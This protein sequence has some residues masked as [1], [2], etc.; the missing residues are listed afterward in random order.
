MVDAEAN[1]IAWDDVHK[2]LYVS[3]ASSSANHPDSIGVLDPATGQFT[4][5][6]TV[7]SNPGDLEVS[8][9]GQYLYVALRGAGQIQRLSL[10][11]LAPDISIPLGTNG[12]GAQLYSLQMRLAPGN[13]HALAVVRST[14]PVSSSGANNLAVFDDAT[15]RPQTAGNAGADMITT[16]QWDSDTRIIAGNGANTMDT[17]YHIAVDGN[18]LQIT[19]SQQNVTS[20]DYRIY[21]DS[22]RIITQRGQVFDAESFASLGSFTL[23]TFFPSLVAPDALTGRAFFAMNG[24]IK[25]FDLA[26]LD[27]LA[28]ITLPQ[29]TLSFSTSRLIRWGPDGL[30]LVR[31]LSGAPRIMLINGPFVK[32]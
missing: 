10:P 15:M 2:L 1:D 7:G 19:R 22:G 8:P 29:G 26:T 6:H 14:S 12:A 20:F 23:G 18:G 9:D 25:S 4:S 32:P 21:L 24:A 28:S 13:A 5:Y 17:A 16:F 3:M 27:P 30:A 11:S 31:Y